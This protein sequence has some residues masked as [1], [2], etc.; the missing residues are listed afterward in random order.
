MT[1]SV[2]SIRTSAHY[3]AP[4]RVT[5]RLLN[6]VVAAAT[7]AGFDLWGARVLAVVG[8]TSGEVRTTPVNVLELDD[9][10]YLVSPRGQT[11]W[12]RN[13]RA[14]GHGE[15]RHGRRTTEFLASEVDDAEKAEVLRAYLHR[16]RFEV[17]AFFEGVGPD[18]SDDQL[19]AAAPRH[20]VFRIEPTAV[21]TDA[22]R[23]SPGVRTGA[24]ALAVA[25][26]AF[27]AYPALRPF[28]DAGTAADA[29]RAFASPAW[30]TS[31]LLGVVAFTLLPLGLLGLQERL[32]GLPGGRAAGTAAVLAVLSMAG[33]LPYYGAEVLG[34]RAV[35][36]AA[37]GRDD[38]SLVEL[39]EAVR[40]GP[41]VVLFAVGLLLVAAA[42]TAAA[43]AA[44]RSRALPRWSGVPLAVGLALYV[45][46][47]FVGQP[48]RVAHGVLM[49]VGCLWLAAAV[50]ARPGSAPG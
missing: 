5:R 36:E 44:W 12:V 40:L 48:L 31:H 1:R 50:V 4:G 34:L 43:V 22:P 15:L 21:R 38:G 33:V 17:G 14:A 16:W 47:Y 39:A 2:L 24:L 28:G 30:L 25:G 9:A 45:P 49:A 26:A 18:A 27:L 20:P 29:A 37:L 41:G 19:R 35:G 32:R 8:R 46:Q 7:R 3:Q 42:G 13:L 11:Q 10:A 6:P 23:T